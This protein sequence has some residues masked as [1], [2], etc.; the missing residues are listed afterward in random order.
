MEKH[1]WRKKKMDAAKP[2]DQ[3]PVQPEAAA[4]TTPQ[5]EAPAA[6]P[7]PETEA[8]LEQPVPPL[9][10]ARDEEI[11]ALKDRW[12]RL[13]ADFENFRKR[14]VRDREDQ[15]RRASERILKDFLPVVDHFEL[16]LQSA[17]KHHVKHGVIE[18]FESVQKQFQQALEKAGVVPIE[19]QGKT[20]D[21]RLHESITQ[22]H[23]EEHPENAIIQ[24]TR[25]G[26]LLGSYV[27]RAAQVIVS[28]GPAP[29][30]APAQEP[31]PAPEP[32]AP[33][34]PAP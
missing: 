13:Q 17:R 32:A 12:L 7:A 9:P 31:A 16:G 6:G 4:T 23:S 10:D 2:D 26:Y 33:P 29:A 24:E 20:F 1:F 14:T 28:T 11:A 22:V 18:G 19:T 30:P 25:R 5:P 3:A 15:I 21:P 8:P 27:L 34:E